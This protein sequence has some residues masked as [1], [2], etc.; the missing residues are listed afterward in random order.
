MAVFVCHS[1]K[2][3]NESHPSPFLGGRRAHAD[4]FFFVLY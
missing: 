3:L 4:F 1:Y 2:M